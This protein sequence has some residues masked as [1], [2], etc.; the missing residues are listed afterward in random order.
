MLCNLKDLSTS[1]I[2]LCGVQVCEWYL[3]GGLHVADALRDVVE[4]VFRDQAFLHQG[5]QHQS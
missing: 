5:L 2:V 4:H 1:L 3:V